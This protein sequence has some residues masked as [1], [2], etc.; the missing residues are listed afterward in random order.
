MLLQTQQGKALMPSKLPGNLQKLQPRQGAEP[1]ETNLI[2][3][4]NTGLY[5]LIQHSWTSALCKGW[6]LCKTHVLC[7]LISLLWKILQKLHTGWD[8]RMQVISVAS[9]NSGFVL[10]LCLKQ[11]MSL[12]WSNL[13]FAQFLV[14]LRHSILWLQRALPLS[15]GNLAAGKRGFKGG[16][17]PFRVRHPQFILAWQIFCSN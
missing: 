1:W 17:K 12:N 14:I 3:W 2:T 4:C 8:L 7:S 5:L 9:L 15:W 11:R 16:Q 10:C 6:L 13:L